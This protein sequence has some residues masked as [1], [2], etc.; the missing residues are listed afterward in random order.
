M[1]ANTPTRYHESADLNYVTGHGPVSVMQ[2][3]YNFQNF[4]SPFVGNLI[5]QLN[6]ATIDPI[7]QM[8]DPQFLA[9]LNSNQLQPAA[10]FQTGASAAELAQL[11]PYSIDLDPQL[12]YA[13]YHWELGYHLLHAIADIHHQNGRYD[14]ELAV[15]RYILDP[16]STDTV[17][18]GVPASAKFWK[19]LYFRLNP[20]GNGASVLQTLSDPNADQTPIVNSY[21][22]AME[23]PF[24]PFAVARARTICFA[25]FTV[26]KLLDC[27]LTKADSLLAR[28]T[29]ETVNEATQWVIKAANLLGPRPQQIPPLGSTAPMSYNDLGPKSQRDALGDA[30]VNLEGQFPFNLTT[31]SAQPSAGSGPL[32]GLGRSLYFCIPEDQTL[33]NYWTTVEDRLHKI[34]NCEN[35]A[36]QVQLMPL[37]DPPINPG[38][39]VQAAAAGLDIAAAIA[40]L[41]QPVSA[42]R[43]PILIRKALEMAAE[44]RTLGNELQAALEKQD[45]QHLAYLR[46][47]NDTSLQNLIINTRQLQYQQAYA[48]TEALLAQQQSA[49]ERY[50]YYMRLLGQNAASSPPAIDPATTITPENFASAYSSLVTQFGSALN[51]PQTQGYSSLTLPQSAAPSTQAGAT[52]PGPLYLSSYENQELNIYMPAATA[53]QVSA[54]N[55]NTVAE[56]LALLPNLNTNAEPFGTG[57]T[58]SDVFGGESFSRQARAMADAY[59]ALADTEQANAASAGKTATYQRRADEWTFQLNL[60]ARE[61]QTI[62]AQLL[63]SIIAQQAANQELSNAQTQASDSQDV[64]NYM[65]TMFTNEQLYGWLQGQLLTQYQKYYQFATDLARKAEATMKWELMRPEVD[66]TTYIQPNYFTSTY[67]GLTAGDALIY[68]IRRL[69]TDYDNYNLRELELTQHVSLRQLDPL[70]LLNLTITDSCSVTVPEWLYDL[71]CPGHYMRRIKT[72][73][74]TVPCV[75]GPY[76]NVNCTATLQNSSVRTTPGL[77]GGQYQRSTSGDDPRFIDYY[78]APDSIVT[79]SGTNDS[80]MFETNLRDER[81]L[82]FE[83]AGAISTWTLALPPMRTFDYSTITDVILHIRYTARD[84]GAALAGPATTTVQHQFN[85]TQTSSPSGQALLLCLRYDFPTEWYAFVNNTG[86]AGDFTATLSKQQFPYLVQNSTLTIDTLTLYAAGTGSGTA[87]TTVQSYAVPLTQLSGDLNSS[88][89]EATLTLSPDPNGILTPT[90]T[91]QVYLVLGYHFAYSP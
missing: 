45:A 39:L 30:L 51:T 50:S 27:Y 43:T 26:M 48:A 5:T 77:L 52:N 58:M 91:K 29:I 13:N 41:N 47:Q 10:Q 25:Y 73:A 7:G 90:L 8:L 68:D 70:A 34:R 83:G 81:F 23:T 44:V 18:T 64:L 38:L 59:S 61:L 20:N 14:E 87:D 89:G 32:L 2:T 15:L 69:D 21:N 62:G 57:I 11:N 76:T 84:G 86:G 28:M 36:G 55:A 12:P 42:V 82:S 4:F 85:P 88:S 78:G 63:T 79:S 17:P 66:A 19:F 22:A 3:V 75:A 46:Q 9:N 33:L 71:D 53:D 40:G 65:T 35:L 16:S 37:F 49:W 1:P 54:A 74:V 60:A 56:S 24:Q 31:S 72:V 67:D 80:G 6:S